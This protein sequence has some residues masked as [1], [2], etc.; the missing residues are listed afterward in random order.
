MT[1]GYGSPVII[2]NIMHKVF[3]VRLETQHEFEEFCKFTTSV[4]YQ[5]MFEFDSETPKAE[6]FPIIVIGDRF[7]KLSQTTGWSDHSFPLFSL[8]ELKHHPY[9][10]FHPP[11]VWVNA[12]VIFSDHRQYNHVMNHVVD[13]NGYT[14]T[15]HLCLDVLKKTPV[16]I[17]NENGTAQFI[18]L[19][20]S[21][22]KK[23]SKFPLLEL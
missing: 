18:S 15:P 6:Y 2:F 12:K 8:D 20:Q 11:E 14:Y 9:E 1:R 19:K 22:Q 16:L 10:W 23:Y 17:L 5:W 7:G 4:G 13:A 3:Q 21:Q